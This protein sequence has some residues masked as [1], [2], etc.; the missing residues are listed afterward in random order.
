MEEFRK[1][2]GKCAMPLDIRKLRDHIR[3]EL[4]A[5]NLLNLLDRAIELI[6]KD[7]LPELIEGFF[8]PDLLMVVEGSEQSLLEDI[9]EFHVNSLAGEYY[10]DFKVNS[11]NFMEKSRGTINW[12]AEYERLMERC[13]Q[14]DMAGK[15]DQLCQAFELLFNL[16]DEVDECRDDIIFFADEG[17]SWQVGVDWETVLPLYFQ[18]LAIV[19]KPKEYAE[20]VIQIVKSHVNYNSKDYF[21]QALGSAKPSQKKELKAVMSKV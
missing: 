12:I 2:Q 14:E 4:D 19:A 21:Q 18:T 16:L 15:P 10:E 9:K 13:T 20:K 8:D 1:K 6:P 17:G 3:T 11:K 5:E 7:Q